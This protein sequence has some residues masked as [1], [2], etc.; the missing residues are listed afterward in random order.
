[1]NDLRNQTPIPVISARFH[2]GLAEMVLEVV[3]SLRKKYGLQEAALSGGVW[4]NITLLEKT[5][6]LL[7][8]N[9]FTVYT[10]QSVPAN[11]GGISLGQVVIGQSQLLLSV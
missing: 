7:T 10:H 3:L 6:A 11:D 1:M 9:D 8:E 5:L 4:Q 2:N